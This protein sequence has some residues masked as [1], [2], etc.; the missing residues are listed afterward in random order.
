MYTL[1]ISLLA[2]LIILPLFFSNNAETAESTPPEIPMTTLRNIF[3][4]YHSMLTSI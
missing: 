4:V 1:E 2:V 3:R